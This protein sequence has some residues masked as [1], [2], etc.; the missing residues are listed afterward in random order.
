M[1]KI[2]ILMSAI[3]VAVGVQA[4]NV[5]W[6]IT[7]VSDP[8]N[9]GNMLVYA[10]VGDVTSSANTA[11]SSTTGSDWSD[12]LGTSVGKINTR[13]KASGDTEGFSK[14]G[15]QYLTFVLVDTAVEENNKWYVISAQDVTSYVYEGTETPS[16]FSTSL[17][18]T[19]ST[20]TFTSVPEPTSGLLMLLGMAGLAL[21]RRRA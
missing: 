15:N 13:G 1:K 10:F 11:L 7:G 12:F 5:K 3:A 21:R 17:A 18:S 4:A 6:Q 2:L 14:S 19:A 20:G 9:T 8:Y 16:T